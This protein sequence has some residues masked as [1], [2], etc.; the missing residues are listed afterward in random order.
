MG[1]TE[2]RVGRNCWDIQL[3][4]V[5][6]KE[7]NLQ[8]YYSGHPPSSNLQEVLCINAGCLASKVPVK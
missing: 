6:V 5:P 8:T 2:T 4:E 1:M 7:V 3:L